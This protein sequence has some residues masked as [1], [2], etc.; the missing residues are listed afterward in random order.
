MTTKTNFVTTTD[1]SPCILT[2]PGGTSP[3]VL[4]CEHASNHIPAEFGTL[5]LDEKILASH[6]A[7]D[8]GAQSVAEKLSN[9]L[10]AKLVQSTVSRLVYDCNRPPEAV[11]SIPAK[12][13]IYE[14]PGNQNLDPAARTHRVTSVYLPF[15]NLLTQTLAKVSEPIVVTI[16][17]FTPIYFG[18]P[19][20][21]EI[22]VLHDTDSR[23]ANEL[24]KLSAN[25]L[26]GL[27]ER[28]QPYG[29]ANGV[30]HTLKEHAIKE[31]R[32]NVMIEI[33]ND[34]IAT[35]SRQADMSQAI[36]KALTE[37]LANLGRPHPLKVSA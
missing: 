14:I 29:P 25:Y 20:A 5:G 34:L 23:L 19:R 16:H 31:G 28:N 15:Q 12:S 9:I 6:I 26:P 35:T 1:A 2:N 27:V 36:G 21:T 4:V 10:D 11:D 30:T 8:P 32:L 13:E 24:L 22:G 33:R 37:A 18:Q 7:W 17:S 3:I